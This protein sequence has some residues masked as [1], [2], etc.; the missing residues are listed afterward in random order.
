MII[1]QFLGHDFPKKEIVGVLC[2][3]NPNCFNEYTNW[4]EYNIQR[5]HHF[6]FILYYSLFWQDVRKQAGGN[7]FVMAG[8]K[9]VMVGFKMWHKK[10][11]LQTHVGGVNSAHNQAVKN[12]EY[13]MNQHIK[14]VFVKKSN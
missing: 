3:F 1:C 10:D 14:S 6:Y 12:V 2:Q 4:L 5:M 13:L 9:I 11:K 7:T 8:F